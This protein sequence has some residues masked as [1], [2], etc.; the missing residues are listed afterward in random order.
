M[1]LYGS[2]DGKKPTAYRSPEPAVTKKVEAATVTRVVA[3]AT[4]V[5]V[6]SAVKS[7]PGIE[8]ESTR[9]PT[10]LDSRVRYSLSPSRGRN[11]SKDTSVKSVTSRPLTVVAPVVKK[12]EVVEVPKKLTPAEV[13]EFFE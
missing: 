12:V 13:T 5:A 10:S 4:K 9:R 11:L 8:T 2:P 1:K 6:S 7:S 3:T